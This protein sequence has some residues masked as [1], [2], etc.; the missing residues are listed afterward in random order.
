MFQLRRLVDAHAFNSICEM[1][2]PTADYLRRCRSWTFG[3]VFPGSDVNLCVS[4]VMLSPVTC[5]ATW[6]DS[7]WQNYHTFV[8]IKHERWSSGFNISLSLSYIKVSYHGFG[9]KRQSN[10]YFDF[11]L[12]Y[13]IVVLWKHNRH[14]LTVTFVVPLE[15]V[16]RYTYVI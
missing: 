4:M 16:I 2:V 8:L 14:L 5:D 7:V 13:F 6:H 3:N 15:H 10:Y 9:L 11:H 12:I 1:D